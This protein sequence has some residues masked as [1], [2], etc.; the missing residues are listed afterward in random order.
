MYKVLF[1]RQQQHVATRARARVCVCV[2]VCGWV[3]AMY[4]NCTV[5]GLREDGEEGEG[6]SV[7]AIDV[8]VTSS[9]RFAE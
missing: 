6:E 3:G 5:T 7:C 1:G 2:C 4:D 8:G 9:I